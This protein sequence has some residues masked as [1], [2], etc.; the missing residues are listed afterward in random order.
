MKGLFYKPSV[1]SDIDCQ[2]E[3]IPKEKLELSKMLG[4]GAFGAVYKGRVV[5]DG[6]KSIECAVK[7]VKGK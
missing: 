7:T 6:D 1:T 3:E 4:S 5:L 2:W